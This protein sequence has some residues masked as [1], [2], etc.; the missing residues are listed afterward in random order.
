MKTYKTSEVA[1]IIGVHPNTVRLYEQWKLIP[2][3]LRAS[4]GYRIYTEFH[5]EV[6]KLARIAFQIEVTQSGL[7]KTITQVIKCVA[8]KEYERALY[9]VEEYC[10][11][12]NKEILFAREAI[13]A[14]EDILHSKEKEP[15]RLKRKQAAKYLDIS[16]DTL[17]NWE[18]NGL[19]DI[20][21]LENGYRVYNEEDIKKLKIIRSLRFANYSL[22]S[23]LR[24]L[25]ELY[26][27]QTKENTIHQIL[28]TPNPNE[29]II[30]VCDCLIISLEKAYTNAKSIKIGIE[31][32]QEEN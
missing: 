6:F 20:E 28:N 13:I 19:L 4:N 24:L 3:V 30:S 22:E 21:R 29:Y 27:V 25:K 31:K 14:V 23:I 11:I 7:R 17:R 9:L 15:L 32:L 16:V 26:S 10:T 5:I 12:L 8:K 18:R 2:T 1:K